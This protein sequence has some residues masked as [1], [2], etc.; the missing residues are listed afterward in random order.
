MTKGPPTLAEV[1]GTLDEMAAAAR[2]GQA[3]RYRAA[4]GT[5]RDQELTEEQMRDAYRWGRLH[6]GP[7]EF[8]W[9]G[10]YG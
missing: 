6:L 2:T 3:A 8:D 5:A 7:A 4:V 9:Q 1:V 10:V